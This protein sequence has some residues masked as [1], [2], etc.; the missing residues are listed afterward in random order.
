MLEASPI[1]FA[2]GQDGQ[3]RGAEADG[4]AGRRHRADVSG[5]GRERAEGRRSGARAPTDALT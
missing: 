2:A 5:L 4:V 3:R 1:G